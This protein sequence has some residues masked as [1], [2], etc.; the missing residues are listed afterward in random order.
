[1]PEGTLIRAVVT[2]ADAANPENGLPNQADDYK[3]KLVKYIPVETVAFYTS[4]VGIP[5][6]LKQLSER[7]PEFYIWYVVGLVLVF[8]G[9]LI[10][11]PLI[12]NRVYGITWKYKKKQIIVS[13]S[14]YVLWVLALGTF[15]GFIPVPSAIVTI[16]LAI[17]TL[18][19]PLI[20]PGTNT[21]TGDQQ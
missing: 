20:D 16:I 6:T 21:S 4:V 9:G 14:A 19:A 10:G 12:L 3:T 5:E 1:M 15:Q 17:F 11:T 2:E 13:T 18:L 8:L 7:Q